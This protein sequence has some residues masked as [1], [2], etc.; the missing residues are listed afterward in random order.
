MKNIEE[1]VSICETAGVRYDGVQFR[2]LPEEKQMILFTDPLTKSTLALPALGFT[3]PKLQA[4]ITHHRSRY[5]KDFEMPMYFSDAINFIVKKYHDVPKLVIDD[6]ANAAVNVIH[7]YLSFR[8][9]AP[10]GQ[11]EES[12]TQ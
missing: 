4:K 6:A 7:N 12:Q 9:E 11:G 8:A 3:G 5:P 1:I 10:K 2:D